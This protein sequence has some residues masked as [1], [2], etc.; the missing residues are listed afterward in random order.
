V[1]VLWCKA[2]LMSSRTRRNAIAALPRQ[3]PHEA[4]WTLVTALP[5]LIAARVQRPVQS[6]CVPVRRGPFHGEPA[7]SR[8]IQT[9]STIRLPCR[10]ELSALGGWIVAILP[11]L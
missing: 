11:K 7:R 5:A 9:A 2:L 1:S 6:R 8:S 3:R 10:Q 4:R